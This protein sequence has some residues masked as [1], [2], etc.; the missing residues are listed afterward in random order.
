M[1]VKIIL[2]NPNLKIEEI[3]ISIYQ[4]TLTKFIVEYS[5]PQQI[6]VKGIV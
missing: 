3:D 4:P 2:M 1:G 6:G 5:Q